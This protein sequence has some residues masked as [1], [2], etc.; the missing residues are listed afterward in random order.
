MPPRL[1]NVIAVQPKWHVN[2]F[3]SSKAFQRWIH[4]QMEMA[5]PHLAHD[6]PNLVVLTEL[7]GLPLILRGAPWATQFNSLQSTIS[8]LFIFRAF[9]AL[10]IM[11]RER[12]SPVRALQLAE[13]E[14]NVRLY[15]HTCRDFAQHY[16]V[17]LCCGSIPMPRLKLDGNQIKREPKLLTN[18]TVLLNPHGELIGTT[19]KVFLTPDEQATGLDLSPGNLKELRVF[20]TPVGD[21]GVA[22]SLDA[23]RPEVMNKLESLGCTVLLQ[24]DAN[25]APWTGLEGLPPDPSHIRDQTMA[26]LESCW[27]AT[28]KG[29]NIRY[30]VNPFVV[31]NLFDVAFDGQS[32]ITGREQDTHE[33]RSYV[34]TEPRHGF[35]AL[36]PWVADGPADF[37]RATGRHLAPN[38]GHALENEYRQDVISA[39]LNLPSS[40]I[41]PPALNN[42]EKAL[43]KML[44]EGH[45]KKPPKDPKQPKGL[46]WFMAILAAMVYAKWRKR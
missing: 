3:T 21:L 28:T 7:N 17:Y 46:Q 6:C 11:L 35:L 18:Q 19:D 1:F 20:P 31:G 9:K 4:R 27:T 34:L 16:G 23:F 41:T 43:Q 29:N 25:A 30:A 10:P 40:K 2:D 8:A 39:R 33:R 26:W 24:P 5:R 38:S 13:S 14:R 15:L 22:I 42:H 32:A 37:L 36:S 45:V 12:V 44:A